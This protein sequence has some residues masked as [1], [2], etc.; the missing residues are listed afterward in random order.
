MATSVS[1]MSSLRARGAAAALSVAMVATACGGGTETTAAVAADTTGAPAATSEAVATTAPVGAPEE[2][3][4]APEE[5]V[6]AEDPAPAA[7][8][9]TAAPTTAPATSEASALAPAEASI[10]LPAIDVVDLASGQT[11]SLSSLAEPGATLLW[12]WAPH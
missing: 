7:P 5:R 3:V 2:P 12:F 6:D 11:I 1:F 8:A 9:P 4:G 10:A